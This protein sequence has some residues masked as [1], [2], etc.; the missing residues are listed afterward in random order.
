[1]QRGVA[2]YF[3][4][5]RLSAAAALPTFEAD[6]FVFPAPIVRRVPGQ[7]RDKWDEREIVHVRGAD[8][9]VTRSAVGS[10]LESAISLN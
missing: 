6:Q 7:M 5:L 4:L 10:A 1:V 8:W 3:L 9:I 2:R